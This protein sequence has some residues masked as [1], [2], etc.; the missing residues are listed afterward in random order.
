[1]LWLV[2]IFDN[3]LSIK[4]RF[5]KGS[6]W[7]L[8]LLKLGNIL[9]SI[10]FLPSRRV[11]ELFITNLPIFTW[12]LFTFSYNIDNQLVKLIACTKIVM[13]KVLPY[14][15]DKLMLSSLI[16]FSVV[17]FTKNSCWIFKKLTDSIDKFTKLKYRYGSKRKILRWHVNQNKKKVAEYICTKH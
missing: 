7:Q 13:D 12:F 5:T 16:I 4:K 17:A 14:G 8:P 6:I 10:L 2:E 1:M 3:N 9:H 11:W 15:L